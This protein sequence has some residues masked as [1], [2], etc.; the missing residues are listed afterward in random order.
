VNPGVPTGGDSLC[1]DE[2]ATEDDDDKDQQRGRKRKRSSI[3]SFT[4]TSSSGHLFR[5]ESEIS[6]SEDASLLVSLQ[7]LDRIAYENI[8]HYAAAAPS[9]WPLALIHPIRVFI[10]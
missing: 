1:D 6:T 9:M 8:V 3:V 4:S 10:L 5:S 7:T 2:P